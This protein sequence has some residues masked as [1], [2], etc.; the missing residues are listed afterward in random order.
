MVV[1]HRPEKVDELALK[2]AE[3]EGIPL[4]TTDVPLRD[5]MDRLQRLKED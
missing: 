1:Y 5:L 2:L 3:T 4:I